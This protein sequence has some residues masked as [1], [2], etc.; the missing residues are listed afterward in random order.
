MEKI[1]LLAGTGNL[2]VEFARAARAM[3]FGVFAVALV[4]EIEEGVSAN[5]EK[6]VKVSIGQLHAIIQFFKENQIEKVTML[7]KVTKELMFSKTVRPD[8][9]MAKLLS[10]LPD[11]SDDTLMLAFVR[12]LAAEGIEVFDQTVLIR[13]LM[14]KEGVLT[15]REPTAREKQDM[16]FGFQMA[17][18]IGG[19]DIGQTVVVKDKAVLAVE[20]IE[21]TDACI[22]RGGRLGCGD[23]VVAK[24][25]KPKQDMRFDLPAVGL[26]TIE[27]MIESGAKAL[28]MEAGKTLLVE[29]EKVLA[30]ADENG[31]TIV[32]L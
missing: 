13:S 11:F 17:K 5:A 4:D 18:A 14:V 3:G 12:E 19:L 24:V 7:G 16:E 27:S 23:A 2:P 10:S 9:R 8:P 32:A 1:G 30:L 6:F 21:G 28:A 20:A 29:R 22:L 26:K 15:K 25:A 31:I